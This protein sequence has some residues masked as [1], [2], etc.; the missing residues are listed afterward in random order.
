MIHRTKKIKF[1]S[2]S[3]SNKMILR[4]MMRNFFMNAHLETTEKRGK[5]LKSSLDHIIAK[6]RVE[7]EANKNYLLRYFPDMKIIRTLFAQVGP[8][9]KDINGGY[10]RIV[11]KN[12][13]ENDGSL[14][15]RVE[16][17]HPVVIDWENKK[18]TKKEAKKAQVVKEKKTEKVEKKTE[19]KKTDK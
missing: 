18:Q 12:Q 6:T 2:G 16:W 9:V 11:R 19:P 3:D 8:V 15:V 4:K 17:A 10:V 13:R 7:S 1:H 5:I 14:M